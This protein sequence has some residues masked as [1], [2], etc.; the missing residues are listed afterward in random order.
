MVPLLFVIIIC[1]ISAE[2][3]C[4]SDNTDNFDADIEW[5][6]GEIRRISIS[7]KLLTNPNLLHQQKLPDTDYAPSLLVQ[8]ISKNIKQHASDALS[9][10][11]FLKKLKLNAQQLYKIINQR[12]SIKGKQHQHNS[13]SV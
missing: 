4:P 5:I 6:S 7:I 8:Y 1:Q 9:Q 11:Q 3:T 10:R 13:H 2:W 12:Q